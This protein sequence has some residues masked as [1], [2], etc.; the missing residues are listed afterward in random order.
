M[1]K[2]TVAGQTWSKCGQF[3]AAPEPWRAALFTTPDLEVEAEVGTACMLGI[4]GNY[5]NQA[6]AAAGRGRW[7]REGLLQLVLYFLGVDFA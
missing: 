5:V 2:A 6:V 3:F 7:E 4:C 1:R